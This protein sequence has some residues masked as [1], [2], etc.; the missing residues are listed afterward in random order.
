MIAAIWTGIIHLILGVL[1]TFVLKRFPTSFSVG[2][3]LGILVVLANQNLILFGTF[4]GYSYGNTL[5]NHTFGSV[6]FT[7]FCIL[8]FF[9]LLLF[10]FKRY[11]VVAPIDTKG[12]GGGRRTPN[13]DTAEYQQYDDDGEPA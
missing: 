6:G 9:S 8:T 1:G 3:F 11:I 10:H 12:L 5:T 2:F 4:H 13:A 7:L